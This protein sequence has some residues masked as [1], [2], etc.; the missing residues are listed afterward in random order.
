MVSKSIEKE[1]VEAKG[2]LVKFVLP[3][4][5]GTVSASIGLDLFLWSRPEGFIP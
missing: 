4:Y 2:G 5:R 3:D 1:L